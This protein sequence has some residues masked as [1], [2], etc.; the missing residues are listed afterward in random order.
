VDV[1]R[2]GG[3]PAEGPGGAP[4]PASGRPPLVVI[5]WRD[6]WFDFDQDGDEEARADYLVTTVGFVVGDGPR[7]L[8]VAQEVLP[9]G[10]GYR[11][12][13]HIPRAVVES[14]E[15]V[16]AVAP[17]DARPDGLYSADLGAETAP[18]PGR[19]DA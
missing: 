4:A 3:F 8:S 16:E 7:F 5:T 9:D 19:R 18:D 1:V 15:R 17:T 6:A 12:I 2:I 10:D 13:T 14:I 11:A